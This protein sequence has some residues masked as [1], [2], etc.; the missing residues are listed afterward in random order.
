MGVVDAGE[1]TCAAWLVLLWAKR[2]GVGVNT[3]VWAARVV[4]EWLHL[5]EILTRL[6]LHTILTVENELHGGKWTDGVSGIPSGAIFN[7]VSRTTVG[8]G[9]EH[10]RTSTAAG[11]GETSELGGVGSKDNRVGSHRIGSEVPSGSVGD[12]T[13]VEAPDQFLNWVVVGKTDLAR[14][15]RGDGVGTGVLN[16]FNELFVTLLRKSATLLGV[17]V[18]VVA[19]DL[20]GGT[21]SVVGEFR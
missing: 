19:P 13:A 12:T 11:W 6:F 16:L 10:W 3:W 5:V 20:E 9:K 14:S 15:T 7:P 2:E 21:V 18:H 17:K 4:V 1:V 8:A